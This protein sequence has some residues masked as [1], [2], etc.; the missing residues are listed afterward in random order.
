MNKKSEFLKY[1]NEIGISFKQFNKQS[2][3]NAVDPEKPIENELDRKLHEYTKLNQRRT[4][5]ILKTY[6]PSDEVK[7]AISKITEKQTWLIITEDWCGDSAQNIPFLFK[8]TESSQNIEFKMIYRDDNLDIIDRF[9]TNGGRAIPKI[10]GFDQEGN[11]LFQWGPRPE[12]AKQ[13]VKEWKESGLSKDEF[14]EKLHLWYGKDR[15]KTL[16]IEFLKLLGLE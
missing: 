5:R 12:V 6:K 10:I 7:N 2:D 15:G 14:N 13:L 4:N 3:L 8:M 1:I 11:Q 16:E 9:L